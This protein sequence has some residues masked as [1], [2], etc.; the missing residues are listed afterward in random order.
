MP[1][2]RHPRTRAAIAA[3]CLSLLPG[4]ARADAPAPMK[5]ALFDVRF[6]DTSQE[7]RDQ[8]AEHAARVAAASARLRAELASAPD[9][10][11]VAPRAD[12]CSDMTSAC[13]VA[14]ARAAGA[15][16]VLTVVA[17]KSSSLITQAWARVTDL[18]TEKVTLARDVNFR[19][20]TDQAWA[21]A[22]RFL[23]RD[24]ARNGAKGGW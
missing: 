15:D 3:A 23:A 14:Q 8:S 17:Q 18:R 5:L 10:E 13:L 2:S 11:L 4:L 20:D 19:G 12:V 6:F 7:P 24:I 22:F 16:A 9:V 1:A 21:R